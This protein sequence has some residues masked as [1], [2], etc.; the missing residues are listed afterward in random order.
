MKVREIMVNDSGRNK[1]TK[2]IVGIIIT[3]IIVALIGWWLSDIPIGY[4]QF[5]EKCVDE[6][7]GRKFGIV[8]KEHGWFVA[9]ESAARFVTRNFP[10]VLFARFGDSK[11]GF[12]DM[13]YKGG[14][15]LNSNSY[16]VT[17][18]KSEILVKYKL[19]SNNLQP[20][21]DSIRLRRSQYILMSLENS[22]PLFIYTTFNFTWLNPD[23]A[24]LGRSDSV[25]CPT[26]EERVFKMNS[27]IF[28]DK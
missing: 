13:S 16:E 6:G 17:P 5:K 19:E 8:Q 10:D 24:L 26:Y 1:K 28:G 22:K 21:D 14:Y 11:S 23:K 12:R 7:G 4:Y 9:D 20:V 3:F 18:A 15:Y 25:S 27:S 2:K